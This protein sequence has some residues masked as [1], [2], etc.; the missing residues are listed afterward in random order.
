MKYENLIIDAT[1]LF[2]RSYCENSI[3]IESFLVYYKTIERAINRIKDLRE[4]FAYND[5]KIYF[6]FD[7]PES[8]IN[9]RKILSEGQYK[10]TREAKNVPKDLYRSL[11]I[12]SE[13]LKSYNDNFYI[14]YGESLE[15]DDLTKP[16]IEHLEL[17][18]F[19]KC[20]CISADL[21]WARNISKYCDW[22][23]YANIYNAEVFK[24]KYGFNPI[25]N[26][27]QLWKAIKGDNSDCIKNA[28]PYLPDEIL[29]DMLNK[30]KDVR[31]LFNNVFQQNYPDKWKIKIKEAEKQI[32][33]NY[34][35]VDFIENVN[36]GNISIIQ[37]KQNKKLL[38]FWYKKLKLELEE[39][40]KDEVTER[41][42]WLSAPKKMRRVR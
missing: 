36:Y 25:G 5:S 22:F 33:I 12:F 21:D 2:W 16:V 37:G 10:H 26:S 38:R 30:F 8:Q 17:K 14:I 19:N 20:L 32:R 42:S 7:N 6:L 4:K 23:N 39:W 27:I 1:N 15:A 24:N 18:E 35:L 34:Q 9:L 40:M 3:T 41:N 11:N 28:V 29:K 31:D 13:V